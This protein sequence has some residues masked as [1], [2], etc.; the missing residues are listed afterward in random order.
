MSR[1]KTKDS[2]LS[3]VE[4]RN[5]I[6][7]V[8]TVSSK[9]DS[10]EPYIP[11][12]I[13]SW[14]GRI[15]DAWDKPKEERWFLFKLDLLIMF[16]GGSG[17]FIRY[18][19]QANLNSAFVS[20]MKEELELYGNEL[21]YAN[22][23]FSIGYAI[24]QIP[25]NMLLSKLRHPH[26]YIAFLEISW[27]VLTFASAKMSG[28][29]M[30]YAIRF[31]VGL[32]EAGHFPA[33]MYIAASWYPKAELSKRISI[34]QF[35]TSTGPMLSNFLQSAAYTGLNGVSGRSGWRWLF[36][37]DGIISLPLATIVIFLFPDIP[38]T[39]K[40]NWIFSEKELVLARSRVPQ[41]AKIYATFAKKDIKSWLGTWHVYFFS[42]IFVVEALAGLPSSSMPFWFKSYNGLYS[43]PQIN[44]YSA[45]LY[46]VRI[47]ATVIYGF[48]SD[49]YL[50]GRR[51]IVICF[52]AVIMFALCIALIAVPVH[53]PNRSSRFAIYA[54][55]G[56]YA[57]GAQQW[58]W[59]NDA[60]MGEPAKR[61]F[62][63][64]VM[65]S[66]LYAFLAFVPIFLFP[67]HHQ[68]FVRNGNIASAVFCVAT[69][70]MALTG[71]YIEK[72]QRTTGFWRSVP[73]SQIEEKIIPEIEVSDVDLEPVKEKK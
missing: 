73:L 45:I 40:P 29:T 26:Y 7:D 31:F 66:V 53:P 41:E 60:T 38:R 42:A 36:I 15:W 19:D 46:G 30:M 23:L 4:K 47:G 28:P 9:Q 10:F 24:G 1:T 68:P 71:A 32:F 20:G 27:S 62:V 5:S 13:H 39:Q 37:V 48:I 67:T 25:S 49:D 54:L 14:K 55:I 69:I 63:G 44:N 70:L 17:V 3:E 59:Q 50:K 12:P 51:Y 8:E 6:I 52:N 16:I 43:I 2:S 64:A 58:T 22:A 65:N 33:V 11:T 72:L 18:L 61:A 35:N 57:N 56:L 34:I 21:N